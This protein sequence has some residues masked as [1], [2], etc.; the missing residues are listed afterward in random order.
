MAEQQ[1]KLKGLYNARSNLESE[2][3][4]IHKNITDTKDWPDRRVKF[5][6]LDFKLK[7]AFSGLLQKN[8]DQ[9]DLASETE[10]PDS[11]SLVLEQCLDYATKNNEEFLLAA[12]SYINSVA[13]RDTVCEG[14]N[15]QGKTKRS[16]SRTTSKTPSQRKHDFHLATPKRE[17]AEKQEQLPFISLDNNTKSPC[18]RK[19]LN[20]KGADDA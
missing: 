3:R 16:S 13:D 14:I 5:E 19:S 7:D 12:R 8:E 9:F 1:E 18:G 6:Q 2:M 10:N 17:E 20:N 4:N 11:I 15:T